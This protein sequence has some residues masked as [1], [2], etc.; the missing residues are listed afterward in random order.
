MEG[1]LQSRSQV[2]TCLN[3]RD[4]ACY[5]VLIREPEKLNISVNIC[6]RIQHSDSLSERERDSPVCVMARGGR[7]RNAEF[8]LLV[9]SPPV[10]L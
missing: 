10:I 5:F 9:S 3:T 7:R 2:V 8:D 6:F 1:K 4:I